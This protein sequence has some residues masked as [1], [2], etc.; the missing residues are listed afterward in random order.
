MSNGQVK[1]YGWGTEVEKRILAT[2]G[3]KKLHGRHNEH[4][5][6]LK[7]VKSYFEKQGYKVLRLDISKDRKEAENYVREKLENRNLT[8]IL[9]KG[10]KGTRP[11]LLA[12]KGEE[13]ILVD[14]L[15]KDVVVTKTRQYLMSKTS[16]TIIVLPPIPHPERLEF[17][18]CEG[19]NRIYKLKCKSGLRK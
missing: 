1:E 9:Q 2:Y 12:I 14:V 5:F 7:E 11:D 6:I 15:A 19:E 17:W 18:I 13:N 3:W 4:T 16:K 10:L 8:A